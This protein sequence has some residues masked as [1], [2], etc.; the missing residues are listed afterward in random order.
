MTVIRMIK[1][2][3]TKQERF[4]TRAHEFLDFVDV[5]F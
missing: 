5:C 1:H 4:S 2:G 3:S